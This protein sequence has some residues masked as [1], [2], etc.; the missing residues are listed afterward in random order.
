MTFIY[1]RQ[2]G[3]T[4]EIFSVQD[5]P[6]PLQFE[7]LEPRVLLSADII[8]PIDDIALLENA[9]SSVLELSDHL[10][11]VGEKRQGGRGVGR[12]G[13]RRRENENYPEE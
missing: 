4:T 11:R 10:D 8:T 6:R 12:D 2:R 9:T 3:I 1:K 5:S 13:G 7:M